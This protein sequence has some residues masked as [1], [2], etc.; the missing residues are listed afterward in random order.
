MSRIEDYALIGDLHTGALV[1]TS[2]SVDWLC[3]PR[4]D[5]PATFAALLHDESA[6]YWRMALVGA[7]ECTTRRYAEGTHVLETGW[8]TDT[9]TAWVLDFMPPRQANPHLVRIVVGMGGDVKLRSV[10]RPPFRLRRG[11]ALAEA[12]PRPGR[13]HR[14]A[15]LRAP[16]Q[17]G[18]VRQPGLDQFG[19][20]QGATPVVGSRIPATS[21]SNYPSA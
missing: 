8:L 13:R 7:G 17:R 4:F 21:R 9:G 1:S 16:H 14:G 3:L 15:R 12:R 20:V 5:F 6:G 2:G 10:M 19:R 11:R 18:R